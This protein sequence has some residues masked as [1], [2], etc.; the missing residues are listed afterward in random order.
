LFETFGRE[1][2]EQLGCHEYL[3][4]LK[5]IIHHFDHSFFRQSLSLIFIRQIVVN[6]KFNFLF[7]IE[8]KLLQVEP[9]PDKM[10]L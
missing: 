6:G 7:F 9:L 10:T 8:T 2:H 4:P 5:P 1:F 3:V